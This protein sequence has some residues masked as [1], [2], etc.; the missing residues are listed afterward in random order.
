MKSIEKKH[1][2][3]VLVMAICLIVCILG[4]FTLGRYAV[5]LKGNPPYPP[6]IPPPAR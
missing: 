1:R 2:L 5:P 3:T 4:S 6:T